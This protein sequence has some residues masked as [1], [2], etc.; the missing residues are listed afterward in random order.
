M[1]IVIRPERIGRLFQDLLRRKVEATAIPV[2]PFSKTDTT[3][4]AQFSTGDSTVLAVCVCDLELVLGAGAALCLV[5]LYEVQEN[6][7]AKR[8]AP[9]LVDN[10][11]EVLNI[12]AQLFADSQS[13]R[14]RLDS[15]SFGTEPRPPKSADLIAKPG[16]RMD[17]KLAIDG[18]GAGR[19]SIFSA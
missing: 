1:G 13:D 6:V 14:V 9:S 7:K 5:P 8:W 16:R 19:I 15:V 2:F 12:C 4:T 3:L 18:Y 17:V 10:F 11:K